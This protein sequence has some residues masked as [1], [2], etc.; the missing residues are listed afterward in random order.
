MRSIGSRVPSRIANAFV[1]IV[2]HR[3]GQG[4]GDGGQG[5]DGFT[6]VAVDGRDPDVEPGSELGVGVTA[7]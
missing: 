6:Y 2:F 1:W 5:L 7:P 4:R 3:L